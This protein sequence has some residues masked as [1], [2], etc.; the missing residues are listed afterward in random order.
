MGDKIIKFLA[1]WWPL[2]IPIIA[3]IFMF[4]KWYR[5]GRDAKGAGVIVPQYEVIDNLTPLEAAV[6]IRQKF[7]AKDLIAEI[8]WLATEGYIT[9]THNVEKKF[10][11]KTTEFTLK[12]KKTNTS[13]LTDFD[14]QLLQEIFYLGVPEVLE[15]GKEVTLSQSYSLFG[16]VTSLGTKIKKRLVENGYY[17]KDFIEKNSVQTMRM[18]AIV[19]ISLFI[20]GLVVLYCAIAETVKILGTDT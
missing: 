4:Q 14:K 8:L 1:L 2:L 12:L 10:F 18:Y 3:F 11:G 9:I 19:F 7:N 5:K 20:G 17:T 6:I 15:E 13:G 16:I